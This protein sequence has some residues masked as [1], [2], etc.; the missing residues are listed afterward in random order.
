[1][2]PTRACALLATA[3]VALCKPHA[4]ALTDGDATSRK[5]A[6]PGMRISG[7]ATA[8]SQER[9]LTAT[10]RCEGHAFA[11]CVCAGL[12]AVACWS[13]ELRGEE[14]SVSSPHPP[15]LFSL[16]PLPTLLFFSL[17]LLSPPLPPLLNIFRL[18]S[19]S[20]YGR[21]ATASAACH[22]THPPSKRQQVT[23]HRV[24]SMSNRQSLMRRVA[25]ARR[26]RVC[27]SR[28]WWA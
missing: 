14:K 20:S 6:S 3:P 13:P 12:R 16:I 26:R 10:T 22:V 2:S 18:S 4:H 28:V 25:A 15:L 7:R 11:D 1:V 17:L 9:A 21:P 27:A 19:L 24:G 8:G 5:P 23:Q